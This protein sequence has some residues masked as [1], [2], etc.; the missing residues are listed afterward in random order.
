MNVAHQQKKLFQANFFGNI[1][2]NKE[3][4]R[5]YDGKKGKKQNLYRNER[6]KRKLNNKIEF[7]ASKQ[8]AHMQNTTYERTNDL[9]EK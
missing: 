3:K 1:S 5:K 9:T 4:N 6:N 8:F 2:R 7:D